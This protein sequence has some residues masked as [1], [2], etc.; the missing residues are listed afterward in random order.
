M[1]ERKEL[2]SKRANTSTSTTPVRCIVEDLPGGF[3][4]LG[5]ARAPQVRG[6]KASFL[7]ARIEDQELTLVSRA[8][9][10][11]PGGWYAETGIPLN[12]AIPSLRG[13]NIVP[14]H[15]LLPPAP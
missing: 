6:T 7:P 12:P 9:R 8:G 2:L 3:P 10:K 13:Q 11:F 14:S 15:P 4:S 1:R 5:P